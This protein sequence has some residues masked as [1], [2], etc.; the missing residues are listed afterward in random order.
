[1]TALKPAEID[2]FLR[3][4]DRACRLIL[5]YGPDRG[6]VS[7]RAQAFS[8]TTGIDLN[9]PFSTVKLDSGDLSGD[10]DRLANEAWTVSMFGGERLIWLK[11][12]GNDKPLVES[13]KA[14]LADPPA[15]ARFLVESGE[16]KK[17]AALRDL[18][19]K[20]GNAVAVP[21]YSDGPRELD[22]LIDSQ[23]EQHRLTISLGARQLLKDGLGGD[24]LASRG[25]I[26]KLCLYVAGKSQIDED[27]VLQ[28]VGD[29]AALSQDQ[30]VDAVLLG[31]LDELDTA[32]ARFQSSGAQMFQLLSAAQRQ[33]QQLET[34]RG[35]MEAS[36][37]SAAGAVASAKPPIFFARKAVME[38]ALQRWPSAACRAARQRLQDAVLHGRQYQ[39]LGAAIAQTALLALAVQSA[40]Q[41]RRR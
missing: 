7:E 13:L 21:C 17:G 36:G 34:M 18:A 31:R 29:V 39:A 30:V 20:A 16:L 9:D 5:F 35:E 25:E 33:F 41:A 3:K 22:R 8:K 1:M 32:L 26:E 19:E 12:A 38:T 14:I 15:D 2:A 24:R 10:S 11:G 27:D 6:L 23:L 37:Q 4:P 28:A 40:R